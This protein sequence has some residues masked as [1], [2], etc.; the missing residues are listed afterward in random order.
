MLECLARLRCKDRLLAEGRA[1][2]RSAA[3]L[4]MLMGWKNTPR[5]RKR[6]ADAA[7]YAISNLLKLIKVKNQELYC[8]LYGRKRKRLVYSGAV[9]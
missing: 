3:E 9:L 6:A 4:A 5:N 2:E 7:D 1:E 8:Q